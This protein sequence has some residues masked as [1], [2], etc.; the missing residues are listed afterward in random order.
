MSEIIK[1]LKKLPGKFRV[2]GDYNKTI[3]AIFLAVLSGDECTITNYSRGR[4]VFDLITFFEKQGYQISRN[5]TEI[6]IYSSAEAGFPEC[7]E[8]EFTGGV[9]PLTLLAGMMIGKRIDCTIKYGEEINQDLIDRIISFA[10]RLGIDLYHDADGRG[11]VCRAGSLSPIECRVN[12][13]LPYLKNLLMMVGLSSDISVT[14]REDIVTSG[15]LEWCLKAFNSPAGIKEIKSRWVV[16]PVDPRKKVLEAEAEWKREIQ[17]GRSQKIPGGN[18]EILPDLDST[19]AL[20]ELICLKRGTAKI[21][22]VHLD[23]GLQGI[24]KLLNS[25]GIEIEREKGRNEGDNRISDLIVRGKRPKPRK[26]SGDNAAGMV[27][28]IP[29]IALIMARADGKTIIRDIAE[30]ATWANSPFVEISTGLERLGIKAAALEDGLVIE[31]GK[32]LDTDK[33]GPFLNRSNA[34]AFYMAALAGKAKTEFEGFE[35]VRAHYAELLNEIA[36]A[37]EDQVMSFI[38]S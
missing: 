15:D 28:Q 35:L 22:N 11:I 23:D 9:L 24:I 33:Y 38:R 30:Y 20:I 21:I 3:G 6:K 36:E 14:L 27:E 16:D 4:D 13:V 7:A 19:A 37:S 1:P 17:I 18:V 5:A 34:L 31:G 12:S 26:I 10:G 8:L 32:D 25:A 2:P 29:F